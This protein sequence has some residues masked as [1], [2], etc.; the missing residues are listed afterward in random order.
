MEM[1]QE[2]DKFESWEEEFSFDDEIDEETSSNEHTFVIDKPELAN[3]AIRK[4][5]EARR[6]RDMFNSAAYDTISRM[7]EKIAE[8][9]RRC[10][11]ETGMLLTAL[12]RYLDIV[13]AKES[14]TQRTFILPEGKLKKKFARLDFKPD[15]ERLAAYLA[16]DEEYIKVIREPKWSEFKNILQAVNGNIIRTDTGEIVEGVTIEERPESF[17]IEGGEGLA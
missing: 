13:P 10:D 4:V 9:N 14:K 2:T 15:N 16:D 8:N 1:F 12:D 6:R 3:W 5:K 7:E 17:D 11:S